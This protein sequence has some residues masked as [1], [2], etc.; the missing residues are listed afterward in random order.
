MD[1]KTLKKDEDV[2][3]EF[4]KMTKTS[5]DSARLLP[6]FG[7][8]LVWSFQQV[9]DLIG[10]LQKVLKATLEHLKQKSKMIL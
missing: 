9:Q 7:T 3:S 6:S 10:D 1:T 2:K 5:A 8:I 4:S